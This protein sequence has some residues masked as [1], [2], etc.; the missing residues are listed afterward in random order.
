MSFVKKQREAKIKTLHTG[1]K[2]LKSED[3]ESTDPNIII[4]VRNKGNK[5]KEL[6]SQEIQTKGDSRYSKLL[7]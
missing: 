2:N 5:I 6:Y 4:E 3:K 7:V 1:L